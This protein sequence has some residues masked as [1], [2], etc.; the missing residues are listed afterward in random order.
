MKNMKLLYW[1]KLFNLKEN[2]LYHTWV[3][4]M[5]SCV[6]RTKVLE[7]F[8]CLYFSKDSFVTRTSCFKCVASSEAIYKVYLYECYYVLRRSEI[9][10]LFFPKRRMEQAHPSLSYMLKTVFLLHEGVSVAFLVLRTKVPC[11]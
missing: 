4:I 6:Q 11:S 10:S 2:K 9:L 8:Q 5:K 1:Y 7:E 3:F